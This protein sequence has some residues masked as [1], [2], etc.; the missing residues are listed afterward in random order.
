MIWF[1][2]TCSGSVC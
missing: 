1:S 2:A